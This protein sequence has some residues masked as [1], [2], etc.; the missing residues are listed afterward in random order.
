MIGFVRNLLKQKKDNRCQSCKRGYN[1]T[2]GNGYQP[3][4]CDEIKK[5]KSSEVTD[6]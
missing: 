5:V 6:K 2:N 3:C 1:G 4:G